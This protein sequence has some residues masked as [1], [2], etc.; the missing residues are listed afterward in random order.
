MRS[1]RRGC[2]PSLRRSRPTISSSL[3][4][5]WIGLPRSFRSSNSCRLLRQWFV[6]CWF[7]WCAV[8]A[9]CPLAVVRPEMLCIMAGMD[10]KDRYAARCL[11]L[12]RFLQRHV[13]DWYCWFDTPFPSVVAGPDARHHGRQTMHLACPMVVF[14]PM[15]LV[16][17]VGMTRGS[18]AAT[19]GRALVDCGGMLGWFCWWRCVSRC[20]PFCC[21]HA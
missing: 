6:V 16:T 13:Q 10:Q 19:H 3:L 4:S 14:R 8:R 12:R 9:V 5:S 17:M 11:A 21:R 18:F 15:M 20:V 1:L 2:M 7:C